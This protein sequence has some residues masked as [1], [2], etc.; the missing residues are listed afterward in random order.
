MDERE[1]PE[2]TWNVCAKCGA[3][4]YTKPN[5]RGLWLHL[6]IRTHAAMPKEPSGAG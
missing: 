4:I 6:D 5:L 2:R 1:Q 3:D